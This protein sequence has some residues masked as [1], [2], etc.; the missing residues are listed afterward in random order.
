MKY[1]I[2]QR[3]VL[4]G[5]SLFHLPGSIAT[6]VA[7][8]PHDKWDYHVGLHSGIV[9]GVN[10]DALTVSGSTSIAEPLLLVGRPNGTRPEK[11]DPTTVPLCTSCKHYS[12]GGWNGPACLRVKRWSRV[13]GW[14]N[15]PRTAANERRGPFLWWGRNKCGPDARFHE[16]REALKT[17]PPAGEDR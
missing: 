10:A 12:S 4:T 17:P 15:V 13:T 3:V 9:I 7:N 11:S 16:P 5:S 1:D 14:E 2:G 6:V 8:D